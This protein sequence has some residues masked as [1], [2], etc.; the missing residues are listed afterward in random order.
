MVQAE[1]RPPVM[2]DV[3]RV[4][5]V[6]HQTVSRV[7]NGHPNVRPDTQARVQAAIE[8]LGYQRNSS[9]RALVTRRSGVLGVVAFGT[10]LYGPA[11][12]LASIEHAARE[13]GYFVSMVSLRTIT[14][15]TVHEAVEFL[16]QQAVEGFIVIAPQRSAV[17]S[18]AQLPTSLPIVVVEGGDAPGHTVVCVDQAGGAAAATR[19]LLEMGHTTVWHIA[20][21][22]DWLEAEGRVAGW[23]TALAERGVTPPPLLRGDWSPR[24]GYHAARQLVE[25]GIDQVSAVFVGNDQ[26]ALGVLRAFDEAKIDVPEDVSLVGFDD[27]PEAAYFS[28]PLTTVW[29][30]F[31][32]VGRRSIQLLLDHL[33]ASEPNA[34]QVTVPTQLVQRSSVGVPHPRAATTNG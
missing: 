22:A 13:A 6:S 17:D 4:A 23:R 3:A 34:Q 7:L 15:Q 24:S 14:P 16:G 18:L 12:T 26:M 8:E 9:A 29:Q 33:A 10:N 20:G 32:A 21:P 27:V 30:D 11:S 28:P 1:A 2:A 31:S 5:G 25:R 19:H